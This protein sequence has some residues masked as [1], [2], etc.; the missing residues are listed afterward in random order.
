MGKE[1]LGAGVVT[2]SIL[3]LITAILSST[4][5][6]ISLTMGDDIN[7]ILV[8]S[9]Q[10]DTSLL[11][12]TT[13]YIISLVT[14][15]LTGIFATLI[16][17]KNRIGVFGYFTVAI[18]NNVYSLI[19]NGITVTSLISLVLGLSFLALYGFFIYKKRSVY[20]FNKETS[21]V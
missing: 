11:P 12:T 7:N 15:V 18:L 13:D 21:E 6:V 4:G 8:E 16:L 17:F 20:G 2:I 3:I 9:G 14:S 19:L 5:S 10:I 1:K